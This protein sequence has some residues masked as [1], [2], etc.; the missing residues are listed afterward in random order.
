MNTTIA[1]PSPSIEAELE[2]LRILVVDD[3]IVPRMLVA[4]LLKK[5]GHHVLQAD[6]GRAALELMG[7]E[8]VDLISLDLGMTDG[9][10]FYV[11]AELRKQR[12]D[13]WIPVIVISA[14][15]TENLIIKAL[16][17]GADDFMTKPVNYGFLRA[18]IRNFQ[19]VIGVQRRNLSLLDTV[20]QTN[21]KLQARLDYEERF[22]QRI[23]K[24]LL[25]GSIPP[26]TGGVYVTA[27]AEARQGVNGDF[28]EVTSIF[29]NTVDLIVGDVM[30][31]GPLAALMGA[32]VK[33]QIQRYI[34]Q[35]VIDNPNQ[36]LSVAHIINA[37]HAQLTH[38]LSEL[39]SFVTLAYIRI[40]CTLGT[41]S[42]VSCGH[43]QPLL[44]NGSRVRAFGS[45]HLP[46]GVLESEVYT[47]EIVEMGPGDSLLCFSDGV[48]DARNPE[49]EAFGEER[50]MASATRC[51]P[52]IWGPAARIDLL[53]RDV[54]EFL[55][56]CA[57]TDDLTMLVA[58]FPLLSPVPKRLQAS[59]ELSQIAQ[60]QAFL[61]ENTTEFNLPDHVCFKLELAVVEV[62][63]N[64]VRHSQAGLQHSSV[65]LLMWCE[66]QMVY[67]ALESIGN[68]FDPSQHVVFDPDDLSIDHTGGF[69][70]HII[71]TLT[72]DLKYVH[73]N[74][75]NRIQLGFSLADS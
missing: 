44:I 68:E 32:D 69:G 2:P 33:L 51:S 17:S 57:P 47:E 21:Q 12:S 66:G 64:V 28:I 75:I 48:T 4:A 61:Y 7:R 60:V 74:G 52:A 49:G 45:Q 26:I 9:D 24:T 1:A 20:S 14:H 54:K 18:K 39:D 5:M 25:L 3:D 70:L 31:K 53:R 46:L 38:K 55:A 65:D 34:A 11:L 6:S 71:T 13:R 59:K 8:E 63:T 30:G 15:N 36:L 41:I 40:N 62:F 22:S 19:R 16:D 37:I 56:G 29:P 72:D 23:Q 73:D 50:L 35:S 27:R 58:V 67:V 43:M 42:A 10:G